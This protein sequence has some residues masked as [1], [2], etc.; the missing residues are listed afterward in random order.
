MID[1]QTFLTVSAVII[2]LLIVLVALVA[3]KKYGKESQRADRA[4]ERVRVLLLAAATNFDLNELQKNECDR[5]KLAHRTSL[6]KL[7][8]V[9]RGYKGSSDS[10]VLYNTRR[11]LESLIRIQE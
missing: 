1:L 9:S 7:R 3:F 10:A 11:E 4:E 2:L 6:H 5:A 8:E